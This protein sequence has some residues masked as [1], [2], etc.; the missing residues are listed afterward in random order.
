MER[1]IAVQDNNQSLIGVIKQ[2]DN[3]A[4]NAKV[5]KELLIDEFSTTDMY[6]CSIE[7]LFKDFNEAVINEVEIHYSI[8]GEKYSEVIQIFRTWVY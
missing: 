1:Y 7:K 2:R 8:N 6:V 5:L 4:D 3:I